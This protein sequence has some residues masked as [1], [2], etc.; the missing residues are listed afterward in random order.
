MNENLFNVYPKKISY[1][2]FILK[3]YPRVGNYVLFKVQGDSSNAI[4]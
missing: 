3:K 4:A 1:I 2:F